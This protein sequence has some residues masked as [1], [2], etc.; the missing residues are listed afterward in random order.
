MKRVLA[1]SLSGIG[2]R[3]YFYRAMWADGMRRRPTTGRA[4]T[5]SSAAH[6]GKTAA[7]PFAFVYGGKASSGLVGKWKVTS[8]EK[9]GGRRSTIRTVVYSDPSTGLRV[10]VVYTIYRDFPAVEWVVRLQE[11]G[12]GATPIIENVQ[13]CAVSFPEFAVRDPV[14]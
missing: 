12:P 9:S 11:R 10:T 3:S 1:G 2:G 8:D 5:L 7:P 4:A 14:P 6:A 13:A